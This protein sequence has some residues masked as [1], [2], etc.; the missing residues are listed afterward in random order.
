MLSLDAC[1]VVSNPS[2]PFP[3]VVVGLLLPSLNVYLCTHVHRHSDKL[4]DAK[5]C[6]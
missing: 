1:P 3:F 6:L 4:A 5:L 2:P